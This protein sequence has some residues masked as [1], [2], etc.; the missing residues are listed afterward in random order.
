MTGGGKENLHFDLR[1]KGLKG[2]SNTFK[3][4][5]FIISQVIFTKHLLIPHPALL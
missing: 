1:L 3:L 5:M 2:V 4:L